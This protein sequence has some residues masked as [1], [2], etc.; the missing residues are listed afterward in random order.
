MKTLRFLLLG[1]AA[2]L[3][4]SAFAAA[5]APAKSETYTLAGFATRG[6][7]SEQLVQQASVAVQSRMQGMNLIT[8]PEK[9]DHYVEVVFRRDSFELFVDALPLAGH[10]VG[11]RLPQ[12]TDHPRPPEYSMELVDIAN[13]ERARGIESK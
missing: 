6:K 8:D 4:T 11:A 13:T 7:P 2:A 12:S 3:S 1:L 5:T 10:R 9:A